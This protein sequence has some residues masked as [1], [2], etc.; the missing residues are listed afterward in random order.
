MDG[1]VVLKHYATLRG[2]ETFVSDVC[3]D[4]DTVRFG[5]GETRFVACVEE[6]VSLFESAWFEEKAYLPFEHLDLPVPAEWDQVLKSCTATIASFRRKRTGGATGPWHTGR[7]SDVFGAASVA[8]LRGGT[9][10]LS[11]PA[12]SPAKACRRGGAVRAG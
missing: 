4:L 12:A 5:F 6:S 11:E 8:F 10:G 7:R 1:K 3:D 9:L 2:Y